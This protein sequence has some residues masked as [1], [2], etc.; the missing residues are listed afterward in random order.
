MIPRRE[1]PRLL[2]KALRQP[3]YALAAFGK[4]MRAY[5]GYR[6][7]GPPA[8]PENITLFL[9]YR[10]NMR[11]RMCGQWG[12]SGTSNSYDGAT[13]SGALSVDEL[14]SVI[15]DVTGFRPNITLFG[16]EPLVYRGWDEVTSYAT[17]RGLRVNMVSN[18]LLMGSSAE[19]MIR[20]GL[21]EVILSLDGPEEVHD[22]IRG[23]P[24]AFRRISE[25]AR[26]LARLKEESG[27]RTPLLNV[28]C[29]IGEENHGMLPEVAAIAADMGASGITF[30]HQIFA[31]EEQYVA[32]E[33]IFMDRLGLPET[34]WKGF[35]RQSPPGIDPSKVIA[36]RAG[37]PPAPEGFR[38]SFYP[39]LTDE[40][41]RAYYT[42]FRFKPA[43]YRDRCL[44][45][46]M[47]AYVFPDGSVRPCQA[48]N[49]DTGNVRDIKFRDIWRGERYAEFRELVKRE[50]CF[51]V[52]SR[53]T[54]FYRY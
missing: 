42:G 15:D 9:T 18:G 28:S 22:R 12:E 48:I 53:C 54:E 24:G 27:S 13:I 43:S 8:W 40:E 19:A 31:G 45:P 21:A 49:Y 38:V 1:L 29:T 37:M 47:V 4:R 44:S 14:K 23:V 5:M 25:G 33:K 30:H 51:S 35:V 36:A 7:G 10:C 46:W 20:S 16:G 17:R 50:R 41:V 32:S 3:G 26:T 52:C 11:C 6:F 2:R 39:N 34:D